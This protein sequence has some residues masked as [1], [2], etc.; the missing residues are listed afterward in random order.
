MITGKLGDSEVFVA[1]DHV[2][3]SAPATGKGFSDLVLLVAMVHEKWKVK[4]EGI[5]A[6]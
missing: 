2:W 5:E 1:D 6:G 3:A 4:I